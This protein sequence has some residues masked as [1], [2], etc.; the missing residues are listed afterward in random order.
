VTQT[1]GHNPSPASTSPTPPPDPPRALTAQ[2]SRR[3]WFESRVRIWWISALLLALIGAYF[4]INEVRESSGDR[5][6]IA[7]GI[8]VQAT[9]RAI[10]GRKDRMV[11]RSENASFN[12]SFQLSGVT[13]DIERQQLKER[14][15][16]SKAVGQVLTLRVNEQIRIYVTP[17]AAKRWDPKDPKLWTD[18]SEARLQDDLIMGLLIVPLVNLLLIVAV[19][20]RIRVLRTWRN[21]QAM[22]AI[23]VEVRHAASAPFSRLVRFVL[24]DVRN[25]RVFRSIVPVRSMSLRRGDVMWI[26]APAHRPQ[27]AIVAAPY[28]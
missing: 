25:K 17:D 10:D 13:R 22:A 6:L 1:T 12:L 4:V 15:A 19:V 16:V 28:Q 21:G 7:H 20:Q 18:R 24:R 3:A 8:P 26:V 5:W 14:H 11:T 9:I 23:V 2:G 27:S